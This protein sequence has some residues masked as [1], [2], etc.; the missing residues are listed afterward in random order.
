MTSSETM[1]ELLK[2]LAVEFP[3][4]QLR[5]QFDAFAETHMVEVSP[6]HLYDTNTSF[7]GAQAKLIDEFTGLFPQEG[8]CFFAPDGIVGIEGEA[9]VFLGFSSDVK[10]AETIHC[11]WPYA[12]PN[13]PISWVG[14]FPYPKKGDTPSSVSSKSTL[15]RHFLAPIT[16]D[17]SFE[18]PENKSMNDQYSVD[19]EYASAA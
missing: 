9:D 11:Q 13:A 17:H 6:A 16:T 1:R 12:I 8:L 14:M 10:M 5:Y 18:D 2:R 4:V 15:A 3:S 19:P 7:K